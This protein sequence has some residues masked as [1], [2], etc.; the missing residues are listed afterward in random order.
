VSVTPGFVASTVK[1][2]GA[3]YAVFALLSSC[4]A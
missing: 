2:R 1:L 3:L 4:V